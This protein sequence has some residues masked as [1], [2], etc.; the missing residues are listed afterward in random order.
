MRLT[1][2]KIINGLA[3][4]LCFYVGFISNTLP[5]FSVGEKYLK[6]LVLVP[7]GRIRILV[8]KFFDNFLIQS[9]DEMGGPASYGRLNYFSLRM[10][11]RHYYGLTGI[12]KH[13][14]ARF[15]TITES[16]HMFSIAEP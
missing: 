2:T 15:G 14:K 3:L 12:E 5:E 9:K 6:V 11:H 10:A 8:K 13:F 1:K 16:A 7:K 4:A